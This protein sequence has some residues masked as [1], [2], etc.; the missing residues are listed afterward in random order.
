LNVE[1]VDRNDELLNR[2]SRLEAEIDE[3][4][5][6]LPRYWQLH[7][8]IQVLLQG[9]RIKGDEIVTS[10]E[11]RGVEHRDVVERL[12]ERRSGTKESGTV[13]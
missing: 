11:G 1:P 9:M 5:S 10:I 12:P 2:L 4:R 3:L 13:A 8:S 7:E 6:L